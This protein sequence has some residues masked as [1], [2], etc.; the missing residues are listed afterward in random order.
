MLLSRSELERWREA[1]EEFAH[2]QGPA[3]GSWQ[4]S[5]ALAAEQLYLVLLQVRALVC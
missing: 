3:A 4:D 1:P 5:L 2:S